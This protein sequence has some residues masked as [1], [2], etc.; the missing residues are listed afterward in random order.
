M[1]E[2]EKNIN[3]PISA[4]IKRHS[5]F[6]RPLD[7]IVKSANEEKIHYYTIFRIQKQKTPK[8]SVRNNESKIRT[9]IT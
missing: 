8:I 7:A 4:T 9:A 3:S 5:N 6:E 2:L 1:V